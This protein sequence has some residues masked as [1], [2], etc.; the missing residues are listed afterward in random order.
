MPSPITTSVFDLFKIGPGPS[1]SHTIGPMK[2]AF[3]FRERITALSDEV[4]STAKAVQIHLY[5]SLSATG[6]GHG[7]DRA[8]VGGLLGWLPATCDPKAL[9]SLL[10]NPG[11]TYPLQISG[12][13]YPGLAVG[14][15]DIRFHRG[16]HAF[17]HP[18]T[19]ILKLVNAEG[20]VFLEEEYY[21]VGGG[22]VVRKGE[23]PGGGESRLPRF[24][25][26]TFRELAEQVQTSGLTLARVLIENEK[27]LTGRSEREI[28]DGLDA[29][30]RAM[31]QSVKRGLKTKG[32]LPGT[33]RLGRKAPLLFE[34]AQKM[35]LASDSF[36]LFLNSYCLAASEENAAGGI[37]VTAPTSGASG[38]F[39]GLTFLM[40]AHFHL[41]PQTIR[42]GLLVGA[43]IGFLVKH[44]ASISGAEMGCMGEI[45][46]ASAIGAAMLTYTLGG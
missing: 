12:P 21:S 29:I 37:V 42:E 27:A 32:V 35:A 40:K 41:S 46:T 38:V 26:A 19:L 18:N 34:R 23:V 9:L 10:K 6:K 44:N 1:S 2:A 14:A 45:G 13:E 43:A 3:D 8:I 25:Y 39:P 5:G 28:A 33:I 7:T 30:L 24:P 31:H 36:L 4:R 22:F 20:M 15:D 11:E 17:P 16:Q